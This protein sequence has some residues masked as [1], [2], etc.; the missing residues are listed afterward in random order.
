MKVKID[1]GKAVMIALAVKRVKKKELE[2]YLGVAGSTVTKI[3]STKK[4]GLPYLEELL[5]FFSY[6][7]IDEFFGVIN[8]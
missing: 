5:A 7:S 3:C 8:R 1:V 6:T 4:G 2:E